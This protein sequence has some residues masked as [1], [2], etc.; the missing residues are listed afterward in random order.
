MKLSLLRIYWW[1]R[2]SFIEVR[3]RRESGVFSVHIRRTP[4]R[5]DFQKFRLFSVRNRVRRI[6]KRYR[7]K[8]DKMV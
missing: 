6:G 1:N 5:S 3:K 2:R 7:D 4:K 8:K